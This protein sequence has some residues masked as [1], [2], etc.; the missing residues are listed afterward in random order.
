MDSF[1]EEL[2]VLNKDNFKDLFFNSSLLR[3]RK[4]IYNFML[5]RTE[6]NDFFDIDMF[7]RKYIKN[8]NHTN[9][10]INVIVKELNALGWKTFIG[11]GGTGLYIYSSEELPLG[12]Y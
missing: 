4:H 12:A 1:G 2:N 10:M 7:N 8:M 11:F 6:E 9:E 3:L 5:Y